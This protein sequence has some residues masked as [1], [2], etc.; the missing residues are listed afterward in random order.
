MYLLVLACKQEA[1]EQQFLPQKHKTCSESLSI[2]EP[3]PH[4]EQ[5]L[6]R[7][8]H[9][10]L[11]NSPLSTSSSPLLVTQKTCELL[12]VWEETE[13]IV[14]EHHMSMRH[15]DDH[16]TPLGYLTYSL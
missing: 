13:K 6:S 5:S 16:C 1:K 7:T 15:H 10:W 4:E 11:V 14:V 8:W 9:Y 3:F 12:H 2:L